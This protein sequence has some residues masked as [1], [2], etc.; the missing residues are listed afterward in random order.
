MNK[1]Q[2]LGYLAS[3]GAGAV[4]GKIIS[5][6]RASNQLDKAVEAFIHISPHLDVQ[7]IQHAIELVGNSNTEDTIRIGAARYLTSVRYK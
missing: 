4:S 1:K 2:F 5:D 7:D 6:V 3:F